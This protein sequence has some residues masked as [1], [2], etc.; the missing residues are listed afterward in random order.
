M[1]LEDFPRDLIGK[2]VSIDWPCPAH[3]EPA[4]TDHGMNGILMP[5][6]S[7]DN[8]NWVMV[9]WGWGIDLSVVTKIYECEPEPARSY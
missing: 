2:Y 4:C 5:L 9:D 1:L 8:Y 6:E 7:S 3:C